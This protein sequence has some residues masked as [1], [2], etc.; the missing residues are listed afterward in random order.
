ME[1]LG[2]WVTRDELKTINKNIEAIKN[3][4]PPNPQKEVEK[5]IGVVNCCRNMWSRRSQKLAPLTKITSN[6]V[7][8][9]RTKIEQDAFD[10]I[11]QIVACNILLFY[12]YFYGE[13][14]IH[15]DARN[16]Q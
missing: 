11:N 7:K 10:E 5:F 6:K 9:K 3:M 2:F 15:T 1:Y 16:F 12:M 13:F 8:F 4:K 14:K